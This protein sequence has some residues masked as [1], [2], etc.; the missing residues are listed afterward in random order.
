MQLLLVLCLMLLSPGMTTI[1]RR[2]SRRKAKELSTAVAVAA[3]NRDLAFN[4]YRALAAAEPGSNV[5]FSPIG[6]S[7]SLAMLALGARAHTKTQIL[8]CLGLSPQDPQDPQGEEQLHKAFRQ[9]RLK[10][11]QPQ[12]SRQLILGNAL[13][14][15]QKLGIRD[16][17]LRAAKT[18]YL[19]EALT[20]NFE[21]PQGAEKQINDY[22]ANRTKGKVVDLIKSLDRDTVLVLA[23]FVFFKAPW[24]TSFSPQKTQEKAFHVS[25]DVVVQVPMM[26]DEALYYYLQDPNLSCRVVAVPYQGNATALFVLPRAASLERVEK[27]LKEQ[28]LQEWLKKLRKRQLQLYLPRFSMEASYQ[29]EKTLPQLGI[30]DIFSS[31]ADLGGLSHQANIQVS[32]EEEQIAF[33]TWGSHTHTPVP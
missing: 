19:A 15:D 26:T 29:L 33:C 9:L 3:S 13:F 32:E 23:N 5:F 17:F 22:V 14:V 2:E 11:S 8:E 18:L 25:E 24:Q 6:I 4:L 31:Q 16:T 20:S 30:G 12:D 28:T 10:L 7:M 27:G 1:G 21:D